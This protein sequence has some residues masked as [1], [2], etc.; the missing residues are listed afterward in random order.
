MVTMTSDTLPQGG[1][2]QAEIERQT[3]KTRKQK[4][5][6]RSITRDKCMETTDSFTEEQRH[7]YRLM[8]RVEEIE[9]VRENG[10]N[11]FAAV[12]ALKL[13]T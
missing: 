9:T 4:A 6:A 2:T 5:E 10:Q 11:M 12:R 13:R 1:D 8:A 3:T 7:R